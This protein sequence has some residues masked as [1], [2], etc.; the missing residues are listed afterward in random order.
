MGRPA[1]RLRVQGL[2][3]GR[4]PGLLRR[5][6]LGDVAVPE[7]LGVAGHRPAAAS[8]SSGP[9]SPSPVVVE[10]GLGHRRPLLAAARAG[11]QV[12]GEEPGGEDLVVAVEVVGA[13]AEGRAARPSR[14]RFRSSRPTT[15][16][17][18][19][20]DWERS[21]VT[22][23]RRRA[24]RGRSRA[25]ARRPRGAAATGVRGHAR[26]HPVQ[27]LRGPA[28]RPRGTSPPRRGWPRR[29]PRRARRPRARASARA[30]SR[31]S[32]TPGGLS[33]LSVSR[34]RCTRPTTWRASCSDTSGARGA[35]D[36]DL[37][38]EARVLDP[39]VEAATLQRVV[40]LT[41]PV[42]GQDH[43][44]RDRRPHR[45]EL[46]DRHLVGREHLEQERL[47]LVV[48]PVDLVDEQHRRALPRARAAPAGRAGTARRTASS[49]PRPRSPGRPAAGRPRRRAG[50][51]SAAGSPSRRAP[52]VASMP[53]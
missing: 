51:G 3:Q 45:A 24:A 39:V 52:G 28:R 46:G 7:H 22:A 6:H 48:G 1:R 27:G 34:S 23:P 35:D 50:A 32:A 53:S 10:A 14:S 18:S 25:A 37:A 36:L 17:A 26:Q 41:G 11:R 19:R 42:G 8:S 38:L 5:R 47:E 15:A 29:S 21:W 2:E 16:T 9:P 40:D 49:R 12:L 13:G 44:G 31:V 4:E 30:Q 33:R 43:D 20:K